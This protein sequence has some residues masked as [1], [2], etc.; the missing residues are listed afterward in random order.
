MSVAVPRLPAG[1]HVWFVRPLKGSA[2]RV[3][4]RVVDPTPLVE[5][6]KLDAL[7]A[8]HCPEPVQ[9]QLAAGSVDPLLIVSRAGLPMMEQGFNVALP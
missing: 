8:A 2:D 7:T 3:P 1:K 6:T 9:L 5:V 4:L